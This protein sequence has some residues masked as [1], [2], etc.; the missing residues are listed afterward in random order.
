G[1]SDQINNAYGGYVVNG[2]PG[3]NTLS[4]R[5]LGAT[6]TLVLV[7]GRRMSPSGSRGAVG[8]ADLNTLP[9]IMV[10]HVEVLK[11]GASAI[12]GSDAVAGVVNLVTKSKVDGVSV[13]FQTNATQNGGGT[14]TR[15]GALFGTS[16][17]NW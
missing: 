13:E 8:S 15:W 3:V 17:D 14:E 9:N 4:L 7:N 12:Y 2:G 16:G 6:R 10:D 1:G 5:G 11:D